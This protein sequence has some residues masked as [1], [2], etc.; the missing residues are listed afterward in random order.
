M[1]NDDLPSCVPCIWMLLTVWGMLPFLLGCRKVREQW[2]SCTVCSRHCG[3]KGRKIHLCLHLCF[4]GSCNVKL[5]AAELSS[6]NKQSINKLF[7]IFSFLYIFLKILC[8]S[9]NLLYVCSYSSSSYHC[10]CMS[11]PLQ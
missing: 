6:V 5:L 1:V 2:R 10:I 9:C 8:S 4:K 11:R 3:R 7:L